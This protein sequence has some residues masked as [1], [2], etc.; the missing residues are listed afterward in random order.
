MREA[1]LSTPPLPRLVPEGVFDGF[2][3][4]RSTQLLWRCP[5]DTLRVNRL[6][7]ALPLGM[8][9]VLYAP[10]E[11]L[12]TELAWLHTGRDGARALGLGEARCLAPYAIDDATDL[13]WVHRRPAADTL[14]LAADN[15]N[16]LFWALHDWAHFHNHGPFTDRPATELQCDA[17]ALAWLWLNHTA[18][19]LTFPQWDALRAEVLGN[20]HAFRREHPGTACPTPDALESHA[21]L[22]ALTGLWAPTDRT[23]CAGP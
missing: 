23:G 8:A 15:L 21:A 14:W 22:G 5:T 6:D 9:F 7:P 2:A 16:A 10:W 17:S 13:L 19:P 3:W 20:H 18:L 4:H 12:P 1:Q 11:A